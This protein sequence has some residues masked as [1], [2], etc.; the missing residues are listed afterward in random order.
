MMIL[1]L[2]SATASSI[3]IISAATAGSVSILQC[4]RI[5]IE[6]LREDLVVVV[7]SIK[8]AEGVNS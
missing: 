1:M 5:S 3:I 7:D 6:G 4:C 8:G 2:T